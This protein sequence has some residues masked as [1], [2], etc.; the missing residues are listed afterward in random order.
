MVKDS[1]RGDWVSVSKLQWINNTLFVTYK[2][3]QLET[4]EMPDVTLI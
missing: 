3:V 4:A 1:K 2:A